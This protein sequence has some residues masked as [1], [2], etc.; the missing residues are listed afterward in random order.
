VLEGA[1][2]R[3]TDWQGEAL[4]LQS[5]ITSRGEVLASGNANQHAAA[6]KVLQPTS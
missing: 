1:G 2:A 6:L 5:E 3:I 4:T